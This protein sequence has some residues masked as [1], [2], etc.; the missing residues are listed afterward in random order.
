MKRKCT[1]E[2]G[3]VHQGLGV[4]QSAACC[5]SDSLLSQAMR[6]CQSRPGAEGREEV[7]R[8]F[9]MKPGC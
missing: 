7:E 6:S 8:L 3:F 4:C 9:T 5:D 1:L 2:R